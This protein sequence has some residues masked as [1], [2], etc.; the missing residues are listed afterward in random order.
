M[1]STDVQQY[2]CF[3]TGNI[4]SSYDSKSW[5][6]GLDTLSL[7]EQRGYA[8]LPATPGSQWD[9]YGPGSVSGSSSGS[10]SPVTSSFPPHSLFV[11]IFLSVI[12]KLVLIG[13]YS[14]LV[15]PDVVQ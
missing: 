9:E 14:V 2:S 13:P 6:D 11:S 8:S 1:N 5:H 7:T 10:S 15:T 12:S 3:N 4:S